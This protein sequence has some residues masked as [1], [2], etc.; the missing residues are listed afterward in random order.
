MRFFFVY[1]K[2][3]WN[4]FDDGSERFGLGA[5]FFNSL[6]LFSLI[7]FPTALISMSSRLL[8]MSELQC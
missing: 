6:F 1:D 7:S 5:L 4:D 3:L 8:T 2:I